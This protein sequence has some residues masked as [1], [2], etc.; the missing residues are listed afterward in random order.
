MIRICKLG[1]NTV[2]QNPRKNIKE[3][4][5]TWKLRQTVAQIALRYFCH[6]NTSSTEHKSFSGQNA[7]KPREWFWNRR[8]NACLVSQSV[9]SR[10]CWR[11]SSQRR[12]LGDVLSATFGVVERSRRKAVSLSGLKKDRRRAR[13]RPAR[14]HGP[15]AVPNR[16]F[17]EAS[18]P[19]TTRRRSRPCRGQQAKSELVRSTVVIRSAIIHLCTAARFVIG[20]TVLLLRQAMAPILEQVRHAVRLRTVAT[21]FSPRSRIPSD[22][23]LLRRFGPDRTW[24]SRSLSSTMHYLWTEWNTGRF[25]MEKVH[26]IREVLLMVLLLRIIRSEQRSSVQN[27]SREFLNPEMGP[28]SS[29]WS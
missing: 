14:S 16:N 9:V 4:W 13:S 21:F 29:P 7:K 23:N 27:L 22:A 12:P 20:R 6:Q 2:A 10:W 5:R 18:F 28:W 15:G 24:G 11:T 8:V 19:E 26:W 17:R 1:R 3:R 25:E